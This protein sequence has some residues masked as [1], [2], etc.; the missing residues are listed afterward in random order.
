MA[1]QVPLDHELR[2]LK[3]LL[4]NMADLVDEQFADAMNALISSDPSLTDRVVARDREVDALELKVDRQCERLLALHT[5]VA[6]DLR[7]LIMAIKINT[8][9]ERIGDHCKNLARNAHHLTAFPDLLSRTHIP[10]MANLSRAM[11]RQM[12]RA[13]LEQDRLLARKV[14][15]RDLQVNRLHEQSFLELVQM[16]KDH[17]E[18]AEAL[19]HL[20][21]ASKALERIA[22]HVK[23]VAESVIFLIEG[24][25]RRHGGMQQRM[26]S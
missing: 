25:D 8:D 23:N 20:M 16:F 3:G 2:S 9:L 6:V 12:Q 13:F 10:E 14:I 17:P 26:A 19:A 4:I 18:H 21:T 7:M 22:D 15:A 5:P 11:L 24:V 1:V